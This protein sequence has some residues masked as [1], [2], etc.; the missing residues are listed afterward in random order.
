MTIPFIDLGAQYNA[1]QSEIDTA[2]A[3]VLQSSQFIMG[4]DV[5]LLEQELA[6][7]IGVKHA[8]GCSSGTDALLLALMAIDIKPGDEVICPVFT[9]FATAEVIAF[10]G[11]KPVFV[12]IEPVT[13]NLDPNLLEAAITTKTKAI[14]PVSLYGQPADMHEIN[15][16]ADKASQVHGHKIYVIEDAAQSF[17]AEYQ[18][19]KSCHLSDI[20]CTSFFPS[21]PLGCYGDGGAVFTDNQA[22]AERIQSLRLH[23]QSERYRH[24]RIGMCGRLDTIQAAILRVKLKH[25][26]AEVPKRIAIG[27][28][29]S[30]QLRDA[31]V[32]PTV[33]S[34]RTSVYAQYSVR[35]SHREQVA[36]QLKEQGV[37]TAVHYPIPLHQQPC[38]QDLGYQ[39]GDFPIAEAVAQEIMSLPMSPFLTEAD[40]DKVIDTVSSVVSAHMA[41]AEA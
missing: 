28:R 32:T 9:F 41:K 35:V 19:A 26:A 31:V 11:A 5:R 12:D 29:Y 20:G 30:Q 40:Q 14:M 4:E 7:Y 37:P 15:A 25:F 33:R 23:G 17:G 22:I 34:D 8:I 24:E 1:Y 38:F 10:L 18:G 21:K 36:A 2:I 39:V 16:I 6:S 27:E 13:Y 3:K